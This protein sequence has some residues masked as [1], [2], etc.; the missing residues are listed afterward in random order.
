MTDSI[1]ELYRIQY[2][3]NTYQYVSWTP[4]EFDYVADMMNRDVRVV[5]VNKCIFKVSDI[6]AIVYIP[7]EEQSDT[8]KDEP[9]VETPDGAYDKEL[10][11][12]LVDSG[13][14]QPVE[15]GGTE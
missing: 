9:L 12:L 7:I 8:E 11:N 15:K 3:D 5:V 13:Y 10:Y 4:Q 2:Q 1:K 14:I 6:R